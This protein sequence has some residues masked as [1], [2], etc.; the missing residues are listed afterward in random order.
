M[1]GTDSTGREANAQ[2]LRLQRLYLAQTNYLIAYV[3]IIVAW[4]SGEYIGDTLVLATHF[5]LGIS[6]QIAFLSIFKSGL[7]KRFKDPNLASIQITTGTILV[8]YLMLFLGDLRGSM[9]LLYPMG[10]IFGVFQLSMRSYVLHSIFVLICYAAVLAADFQF[11]LSDRDHT[12]QLVEWAALACFLGW[13]C[14]F[15][16]YVRKLKEQLQ[17][18]HST[19]RLHQE[20]LKGMMGQLQDLAATDSLTGLP[21]RR[22]FIDESRRR[23]QLLGPGKTLGIALVDLD[24]FKHVNDTCGHAAGDEVLQGFARVAS[25]NLRGGDL[26]ARFGGEEF[27]LLLNNSDMVSLHHCLD[28][29]RNAFSR[30]EFPCLPEG[31]YCTLSAGLALIQ[32]G[33]ELEACISAADQALYQAKNAGRNRCE[34]FETAYA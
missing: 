28:R 21:N 32:P 11:R 24:H 30:T 3:L 13:L 20:T 6:T 12:V 1:T 31:T 9:L 5:A 16:G 29:I 17:E 27:I 8:S 19:L 34:A 22:H 26:V 23:I 18:R 33:D 10:L 7:N 2:A 14:V 15:A 4:V 25:E